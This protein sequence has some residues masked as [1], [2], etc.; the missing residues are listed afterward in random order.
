MSGTALLRAKPKDRASVLEWIYIG[1]VLRS[2][3]KAF[4]LKY[5]FGSMMRDQPF[6]VQK[7]APFPLLPS[8][9]CY[10]VCDFD[11]TYISLVRYRTALENVIALYTRMMNSATNP[12]IG[13][14][15]ALLLEEQPSE[16]QTP[17]ISSD[18]QDQ[19]CL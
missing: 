17:Q 14:A 13:I 11:I 12:F 2:K 7:F 1:N 6:V 8:N 15:R 9:P 4:K 19:D 5:Y 3:F 10:G 18:T 16:I